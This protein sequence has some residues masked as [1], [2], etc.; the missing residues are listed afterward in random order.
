MLAPA[1]MPMGLFD[2]PVSALS[3]ADTALAVL[4]P[5]AAR[6]GIWGALGAVLSMGLYWL[7]SPQR[8]LMRIAAEERGLKEKLRDERASLVEGLASA[9]RL[10]Y[11]AVMR[12]WLLVPPVIA[13]AV[14]VLCLMPWLETQYAYELPQ[15][16]Q[17]A[18][19]RTSPDSIQGMWI[20]AGNQPP[21]IELRDEKGLVVQ[22][23]SIVAPVPS[24]QKRVWWN[25]LFGNPLGYLPDE[26][27]IE[28]IDID[29]PPRYFLTVG[30][31][32]MRSWATPFFASLLA[33]SLLIKLIFRIR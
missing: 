9:R 16:E 28:R 27:P 18:T 5:D 22:T 26:G 6:I 30:P 1:E 33:M 3:W 24:I 19:V 11:L 8:H 10:M 17:A 23:Q 15:P 7:V 20:A 12:L 31:D 4:L 14:P 21:R 13:A 29:L 32:W 25:R 2:L